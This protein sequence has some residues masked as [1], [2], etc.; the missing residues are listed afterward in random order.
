MSNADQSQ[1]MPT[2]E[3]SVAQDSSKSKNWK[4]ISQDLANLLV[5]NLNRNVS[6]ADEAQAD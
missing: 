6:Q 1:S 2:E 4:E 3:L 5:A